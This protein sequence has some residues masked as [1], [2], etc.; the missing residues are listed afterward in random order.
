M[1]IRIFLEREEYGCLFGFPEDGQDAHRDS[2]RKA[3]MPTRMPLEMAGYGASGE[4]S[5]EGGR[6]Q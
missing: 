5:K 4:L 1:P 2:L 3:R 6:L